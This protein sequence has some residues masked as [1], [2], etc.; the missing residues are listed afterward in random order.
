MDEQPYTH[1]GPR[2]DGPTEADHLSMGYVIE[3]EPVPPPMDESVPPPLDEPLPAPVDDVGS[4]TTTT[5]T[6][7]LRAIR[8]VGN[9]KI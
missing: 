3:D 5:T 9:E 6:A 4:G 2:H 1:E 7:R 8:P